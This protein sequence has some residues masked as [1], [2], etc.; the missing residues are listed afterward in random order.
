M[1][2]GAFAV[3]GALA[4]AFGVFKLGTLGL[5]DLWHTL[6][7]LGGGVVAHDALFAPVVLL[8]GVAGAALLPG[9]AKG[10]VM[11]GTVVLATVTIAVLPTLARVGAQPD[12]PSLLDRPYGLG[13]AA[14]T[15]IVVVGVVLGCV[16]GRRR[17]GTARARE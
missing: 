6:L 3:T 4:L 17:Q 11:A 1:T 13:W 12:L 2:R 9:W 16:R 14:F 7:W 5:D 10:P 15:G 8:A